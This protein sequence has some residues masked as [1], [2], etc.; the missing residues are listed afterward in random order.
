MRS[1]KM[2]KLVLT[3]LF[4][5]IICASTIV[6]QIPSPMSGYINLGDC[7]VLLAGWLL[8]PIYG[9]LAGGLGSMLADIFTGYMHYAPATLI[10]KG[11]VALVASL[12]MRA[13]EKSFF[14]HIRIARVISGTAAEIV[15]VAGYFG[16]AALFLGNGLAAAAS[17]PGNLM[18]GAIGVVA[19]VLLIEIVYKFNLMKKWNA[20]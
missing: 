6:I 10:I 19:S 5:A 11:L 12:L 4:V 15:M 18:Q 1:N 20:K 9:F 14:K 2:Y 7:F 8:G 13:M 3:S 17:I 16:Y